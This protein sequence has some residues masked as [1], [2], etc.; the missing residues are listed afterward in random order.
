MGYCKCTECGNQP[1]TNSENKHI[2]Q[3]GFCC[4]CKILNNISQLIEGYEELNLK[5][6]I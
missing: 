1:K 6:S 5:L 2:I 4:D 3:T